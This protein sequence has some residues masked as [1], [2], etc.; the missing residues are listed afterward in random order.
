MQIYTHTNKDENKYFLYAEKE[1]GGDTKIVCYHL[2]LRKM[3]IFGS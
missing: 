1:S 3:G 2:F